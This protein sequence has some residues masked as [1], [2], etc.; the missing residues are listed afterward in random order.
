MQFDVPL[1]IGVSGEVFTDVDS[2]NNKL[3]RYQDPSIRQ[4]AGD[5]GVF[6]CRI[7]ISAFKS[8]SRSIF[9]INELKLVE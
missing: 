9:S 3:G 8:F 2:L 6:V 1:S 4:S 7:K 5:Q